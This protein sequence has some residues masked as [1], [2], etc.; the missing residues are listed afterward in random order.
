M[1]YVSMQFCSARPDS[2]AIY[3][4]VDYG[5]TWLPFQFYSSDCRRTYNK[6]VR[7]NVSRVNE[8]EPICT[9]VYSNVDQRGH[10]ARVAFSTLEGRPSATEYDTSPVLQVQGIYL[11]GG[12]HPNNF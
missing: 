12:E 8:Q 1:T 6:P 10:G 2:M 7:G 3:K 11:F 4:S 5:R 9:D